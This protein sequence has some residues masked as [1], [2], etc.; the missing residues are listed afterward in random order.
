MRRGAAMAG[1]SGKSGSPTTMLTIT[2]A[3]RF[4]LLGARDQLHHMKRLDVGHA[5]GRAR[6]HAGL[7]N[8]HL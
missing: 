4:Q 6:G 3:L 1:A 2:A 8:I 5:R 7:R